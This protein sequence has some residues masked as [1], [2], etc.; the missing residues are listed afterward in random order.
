MPYQ[1][2]SYDWIEELVNRDIVTGV[3]LFN[4]SYLSG[5]YQIS[6]EDSQKVLSDMADASRLKRIY[7]VLCSGP[8]QHF[9][10]DLEV[11]NPNQIPNYEITCHVCGDR[12]KP[13]D[14]CILI[15][16]SPTEEYKKYLTSALR[17]HAR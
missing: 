4:A 1:V 11:E 17:S 16:F 14:D 8:N 6:I 13:S 15:Y 9:D 12:Y 10:I 7:R 2:Y 5:K 3:E